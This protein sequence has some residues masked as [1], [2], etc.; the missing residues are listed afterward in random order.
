MSE[1]ELKQAGK[2]E[3]LSNKTFNLDARIKD[4]FFSANYFFKNHKNSKNYLNDK[5]VT[6]QWFCRNDEY[7]VC[8]LDESVEC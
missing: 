3:R 6:A 2:I 8:G 1:I 4:G 7:M 5:V